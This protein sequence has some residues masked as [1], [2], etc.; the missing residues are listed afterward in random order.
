MM[1]SSS[2]LATHRLALVA[3]LGALSFVLMLFEFPIIPVA[4]YLKVD[5]SDVIV[6]IATLID[7]PVT[8]I[9]VAV[10]KAVLHA[11]VN[12][13]SVGTL[14]GSFSDLLAAVALLLPFGWLMKRSRS[15]KQFWASAVVGT[16]LMT[17]LMALANWW[18]LTPLYMKLWSWKPTLP[19]VQLVVT[20]VVPFNLVKGLLVAVVTALIYFHLPARLINRLK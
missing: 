12:G 7:G 3:C 2:S 5:F 11:L 6:L 16:I 15:P 18:V 10:M 4:P 9:A 8:G 17:V 19:I 20:G 14:L 1:K 13:L